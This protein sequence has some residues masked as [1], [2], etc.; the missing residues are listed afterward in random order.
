[1][2]LYRNK[3]QWAVS[4]SKPRLVLCMHCHFFL[5]FFSKKNSRQKG[6]ELFGTANQKLPVAG[7]SYLGEQIL[8][9]QIVPPGGTIRH[10]T[11]LG[12]NVVAERHKSVTR[13]IEKADEHRMVTLTRQMAVGG[14]LVV[15]RKGA[16]QLALG[17]ERV[18][19]LGA[20]HPLPC[21]QHL[22]L[23]C[24]RLGVLALPR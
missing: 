1:M 21:L 15:P 7:G 22:A 13:D 11:V 18:G 6:G 16:P 12:V 3:M 10:L 17:R 2:T 24:L 19:M 23:Q 5:S 20:Q 4:V 9:V 14:V 8:A